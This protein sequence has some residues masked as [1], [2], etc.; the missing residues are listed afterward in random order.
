MY[1]LSK[2]TG[3]QNDFDIS[4]STLGAQVASKQ[5]YLMLKSFDNW[6]RR[7]IR[8]TLMEKEAHHFELIWAVIG[9]SHLGHFEDHRFKKEFCSTACV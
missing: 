9:P 2:L 3:V 7:P 4:T 8:V 1:T 6:K 5:R